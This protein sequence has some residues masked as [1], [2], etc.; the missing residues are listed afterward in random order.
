MKLRSTDIPAGSPRR[1]REGVTLIELMVSVAIISI[2]FVAL[3]QG[4][5]FGTISLSRSREDQRATQVLLDKIEI[6]R[7]YSWD[8][9]N[10]NGFIPTSFTEPFS[11]GISNK[12]LVVGYTNEPGFYYYG[13]IQITS[14]PFTNAYS[15]SMKQ[16]N[17]TLKWTNS[18]LERERSMSTFVSEKGLQKYVY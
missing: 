3:Y 15:S 18:G 12:T 14:P 2:L 13:T 17:I 6:M 9:I 4:M 16:V 7:L 1:S 5:T 11:Y 8:Q 10:S